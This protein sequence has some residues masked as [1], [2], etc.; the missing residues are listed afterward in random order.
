[1]LPTA[2]VLQLLPKALVLRMLPRGLALPVHPTRPPPTNQMQ[3]RPKLSLRRDLLVARP[4]RPPTGAPP[5]RTLVLR[6]PAHRVQVSPRA[7]PRLLRLRRL[8][9]PAKARRQPP[10]ARAVRRQRRL[11]RTLPTQALRTSQVPRP[12]TGPTR[13][14]RPGRRRLRREL[15]VRLRAA[16]GRLRLAARPVQH[17]PPDRL[18]TQRLV[19]QE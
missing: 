6:R 16:R 13:R 4:H 15:L 5:R 11:R 7:N 2:P 17:P 3:R 12:L 14:H 10:Q 1:V 8:V 19:P 9:R 18:V